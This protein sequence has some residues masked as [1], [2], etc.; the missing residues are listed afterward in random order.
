MENI[1]SK[2]NTLN[3]LNLIAILKQKTGNFAYQMFF[4]SLL[5]MSPETIDK[6]ILH[7]RVK[8]KTSEK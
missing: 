5:F 8:Y 4:N 6:L 2:L 1:K 3:A 7:E